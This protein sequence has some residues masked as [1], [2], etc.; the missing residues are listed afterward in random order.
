M[1]KRRR[2]P[3][4]PSV[5][6]F[7]THGPR[8]HPSSSPGA[9]ITRKDEEA[10]IPVGVQRDLGRRMQPQRQPRHR[11]PPR[12][13]PPDDPIG[14]CHRPPSIAKVL[15]SAMS[16]SCPIG[17]PWSVHSDPESHTEQRPLPSDHCKIRAPRGQIRA[18][19]E[20]CDAGK[21]R[22]PVN[23]PRNPTPGGCPCRRP[24]PR[25]GGQVHRVPRDRRAAGRPVRAACVLRLHA[26]AVAGADP[27][28]R[29][30]SSRCGRAGHP[31]TSRVP[32]SRFDATATGFVLEVE[33]E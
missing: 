25:P 5:L 3:P 20:Q 18:A 12:G 7:A 27:R 22:L 8:C 21:S 32:R 33:E 13:R 16:L 23:G 29:V 26:P 17:R 24:R 31:G 9:L 15:V 4:R 11:L 10:A 19:A 6:F 1:S 28:A 30:T 2:P 14:R